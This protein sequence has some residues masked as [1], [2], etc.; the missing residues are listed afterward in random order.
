LDTLS[1]V[2]T[3]RRVFAKMFKSTRENTCVKCNVCHKDM[4]V[5]RQTAEHAK[6]IVKPA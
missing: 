6:C 5:P 4:P 2:M 3:T 1:Y